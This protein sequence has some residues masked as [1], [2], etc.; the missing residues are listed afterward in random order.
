MLVGVFAMDL[1]RVCSQGFS[2]APAASA[3]GHINSIFSSETDLNKSARCKSLVAQVLWPN[4]L[5]IFKLFIQKFTLR[6]LLINFRSWL[7]GLK[8]KKIEYS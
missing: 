4:D 2:G 6:R 5:I 3:F 8:Y 1:R 7:N